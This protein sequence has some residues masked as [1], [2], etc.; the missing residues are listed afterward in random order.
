MFGDVDSHLPRDQTMSGSNRRPTV[1]KT[2][3]ARSASFAFLR[4][5]V[6]WQRLP[7]QTASLSM[8]T[9]TNKS[10][11]KLSETVR[12]NS[13]RTMTLWGLLRFPSKSGNAQ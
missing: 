10:E 2:S 12:K 4:K 9:E 3:L 7:S 6:I 8:R 1:Y 13:S 5:G 11:T